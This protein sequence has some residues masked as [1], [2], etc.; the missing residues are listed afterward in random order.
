MLKKKGKDCVKNIPSW[1][2]NLGLFS[3]SVLKSLLFLFAFFVKAIII[4]K[5]VLNDNAKRQAENH[6]KEITEDSKSFRAFQT[7]MS[8]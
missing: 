2:Y 3:A 6:Y 7:T 5:I 4:I 8:Y 1:E